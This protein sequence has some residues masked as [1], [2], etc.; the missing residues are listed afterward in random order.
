[1]SSVKIAFR[2]RKTG[3]FHQAIVN[4]LFYQGAV[5][6]KFRTCGGNFPLVPMI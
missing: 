6:F 5:L 2:A 4:F 1:M 3:D